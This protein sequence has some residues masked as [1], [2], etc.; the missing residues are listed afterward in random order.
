[1]SDP[2][3]KDRIGILG[4]GNMG[5]AILRGVL[6]RKVVAPE[7]LRVYDVLQHRVEH[8][9]QTYGVG[10]A[11]SLHELVENAD[12]IVFSAK[13]QNVP[14]ALGGVA[15]LLRPGQWIASIAAGVATGTLERYLPPETPVVRVMPNIAATVG[16]AISALCPGKHATSSHL[17]AAEAFFRGIGKTVRVDEFLMDAV[18]GLSGSGPAFVCVVIEALLDAGVRQGLSYDQARL[19]AAQTVYGA[20]KLILESQ[21]HPAV[22]KSRVTSPGGTTAAGLRALE[23]LGLRAALDAAVAEATE[24]SRELGQKSREAD[25]H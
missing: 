19:L 11:A 12:W 20:A 3:K 17:A 1:M 24:R 7:Q 9:V 21:E 10:G 16:E 23:A 13:P 6:A 15:P 5:E 2:L 22:W 14:E 18:T 4:A 8:C 25:P